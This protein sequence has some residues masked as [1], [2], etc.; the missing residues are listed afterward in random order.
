MSLFCRHKEE[1]NAPRFAMCKICNCVIQENCAR[2]VLV[3]LKWD[4]I[5]VTSTT[6]MEYY[7]LRHKRNYEK[8]YVDDDLK[9]HFYKEF[10]VDENGKILK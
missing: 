6:I 5:D 9:W 1:D 3:I 7:C 10:E 2:I 4:K 8:V